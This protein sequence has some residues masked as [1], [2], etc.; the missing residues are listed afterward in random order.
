MQT[1][2]YNDLLEKINSLN[3][4]IGDCNNILISDQPIDFVYE[5]ANF[6]TKSFLVNLCGYLETYLKDVLE[7]LI[8]EYNNRLNQQK[9]PY[10]LV[11]WNIEQ[12]SN[13]KSRVSSLLDDKHCRDENIELKL[14]KKDLDSFISGNPFRTREL[15]KMFGVD[16]EKNL[17]FNSMKELIKTIVEKRNNILHHNDDASDIGNQDIL[18]YI[19]EFIIYSK[20]IDDEILKITNPTKCSK[21]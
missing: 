7:I 4:T 16:L 9:V 8:I 6:L 17:T 15:F 10:N 14:K 18:K 3:K 19:E 11:R 12:K 20:I 1:N 21:Q 13:S 2:S 5:N